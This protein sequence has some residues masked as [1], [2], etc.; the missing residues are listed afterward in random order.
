MDPGGALLAKIA[1]RIAAAKVCPAAYC[2]S[3]KD[4]TIGEIID[5]C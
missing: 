5:Q 3:D 1:G 4:G 2:V